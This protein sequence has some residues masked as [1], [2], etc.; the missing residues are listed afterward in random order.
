MKKIVS[1]MC[2]ILAVAVASIGAFAAVP[3]DTINDVGAVEII[4]GVVLTEDD[5]L[6]S[7][8]DNEAIYYNAR[9]TKYTIV[10]NAGAPAYASK[11]TSNYIGSIPR[12]LTVTGM[13]SLTGWHQITS[14]TINGQ[15]AYVYG[16]DRS[17]YTVE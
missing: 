8:G 13:T 1:V 5:V 4:E 10:W 3:G 2:A 6:V 12:K 11:S 17:S 9:A 15:T 16:G 7:E 14:Y